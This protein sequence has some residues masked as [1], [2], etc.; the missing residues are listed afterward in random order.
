MAPPEP[1]YT[2]AVQRYHGRQ[3][4]NEATEMNMP[5]F[6]AEVTLHKRRE[7]SYREAADVVASSNAVWPAMRINIMNKR[8]AS[9]WCRRHGAAFMDEGETTFTYGCYN[10]KTGHGLFCGGD[11]PQDQETCDKF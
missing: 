4:Q 8:Q 9:A 3:I 2:P 7:C 10:S 11:S 6:T 1:V 5:G